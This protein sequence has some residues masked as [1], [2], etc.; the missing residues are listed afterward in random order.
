MEYRAQGFLLHMADL[1]QKY[2]CYKKI[3]SIS[4]YVVSYRIFFRLTKTNIANKQTDILKM[5]IKSK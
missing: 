5:K 2:T 4:F 1:Q 3:I